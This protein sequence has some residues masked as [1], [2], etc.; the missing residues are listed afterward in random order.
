MMALPDGRASDTK[1]CCRFFIWKGIS[2]LNMKRLLKLIFVVAG[3]L[4]TLNI[5]TVRQAAHYYP[6]SDSAS[7]GVIVPT[8]AM[9]KQKC[10]IPRRRWIRRHFAGPNFQRP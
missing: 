9:Y 10:K 7:A 5:L 8:L 2:P 1:R 4:L 6:P 3:I